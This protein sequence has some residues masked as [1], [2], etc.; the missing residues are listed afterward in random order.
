MRDAEKGSRVQASLR[1]VLKSGNRA[2]DLVRQILDFSRKS[3]PERKPIRLV[4]IVDEVVGMMLSVL[5]S[6]IEIRR[7]T[8]AESD[9][10]L[11][12]KT[13]IQ[14]VLMNLCTNAFHAMRDHVGV[15]EIDL[16][17]VDL[18]SDEGSGHLEIEPGRYLKLT[19]SDTGHGIAAELL[20]KIFEPYFTTKE[21]GVGTGM[22]LAVAQGIAKTHKG[23]ITVRSAPGEGSAFS[24]FLPRLEN[25]DGIEEAE[26]SERL[27]LGN[28]RV[29]FVDDEQALVLTAQSTLEFLG[30]RV[31][32][33]TSS[34][35]ALEVFRDQPE[36][37]DLVIT[38][39]TMPAMT[40]AELARRILE[41]RP[42]IP[43]ILCTGFS[44][45][46]SEVKAREMGISGFAM[47]P[48]LMRDFAKT[49]RNVLAMGRPGYR[50]SWTP[51]R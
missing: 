6:T 37:F 7:S 15:L 2:K 11:A 33:S 19:V 49:I 8:K 46:V 45:V 22:G 14:Q 9:I 18:D 40:G 30:Y 17:E 20:G 26:E 5:P 38:D 4:P 23:A 12:D 28:E 31:T 21:K 42:D 1:Q 51:S 48:L 24:L 47:K 36:E 10:V 29:L 32:I 50:R 44:E 3:E 43:I 35:E 16:A 13:Q 41:I 27:P 34:V 39:Q 25:E